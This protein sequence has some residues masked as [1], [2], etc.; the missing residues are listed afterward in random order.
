MFLI[1]YFLRFF[2][3]IFKINK[4]CFGTRKI[5]RVFFRIQAGSLARRNIQSYGYTE[6]KIDCFCQAFLQ[7]PHRIISKP[8]NEKKNFYRLVLGRG[9]GIISASPP[10]R[11]FFMKFSK[12]CVVTGYWMLLHTAGNAYEVKLIKLKKTVDPTY[13]LLCYDCSETICRYVL[14]WM[15]TNYF[16]IYIQWFFHP[17]LWDILCILLRRTVDRTV[18]RKVNLI[19]PLAF[20]Q[21]RKRKKYNKNVRIVCDEFLTPCHFVV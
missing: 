7:S 14:S 19:F 3:F 20:W 1:K 15:P 16:R 17:I 18:P 6:A 2:I 10:N 5:W 11:C 21:G 12:C 13:P 4:T 8:Q 9:G